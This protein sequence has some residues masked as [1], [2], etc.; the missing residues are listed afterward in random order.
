VE[1]IA[2]HKVSHDGIFLCKLLVGLSLQLSFLTLLYYDNDATMQLTE[3]HK[4]YC[5]RKVAERLVGEF[6]HWELRGDE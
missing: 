3:D 4:N 1:Y 5:E 2:L 6:V